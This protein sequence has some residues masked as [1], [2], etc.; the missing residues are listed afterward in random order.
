MAKELWLVKFDFVLAR[1]LPSLMKMSS[2][3]SKG[4]W[5]YKFFVPDLF[6]HDFGKLFEQ[7][8]QK[9]IGFNQPVKCCMAKGK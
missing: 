1:W 3:L 9:W 4:N 2:G 7:E 5:R 6:L 8:T